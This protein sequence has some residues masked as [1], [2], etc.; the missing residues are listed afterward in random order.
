MPP[1]LPSQRGH[2]HMMSTKFSNFLT[3]SSLDKSADFVDFAC[4]LETPSP[5]TADIICTS[6]HSRLTGIWFEAAVAYEAR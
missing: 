3:P 1:S 6:L 5:P 2:V 4:Y